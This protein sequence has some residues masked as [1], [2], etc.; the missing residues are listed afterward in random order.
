MAEPAVAA[1]LEAESTADLAVV[2]A[3]SAA[4]RAVPVRPSAKSRNLFSTLSNVPV[5]VGFF[6]MGRSSLGCI[7]LI[8][9]VWRRIRSYVL[10]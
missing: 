3:D 8:I 9:I 1:A 4:E 6:G 10:I 2:D 5:S 7:A